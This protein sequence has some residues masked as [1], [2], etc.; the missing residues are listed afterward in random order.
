MKIVWCILLVPVLLLACRKKDKDKNNA[1]NGSN[2]FAY[3][4]KYDSVISTPDNLTYNFAFYINVSAGNI[5]SNRLTCSV[6]GLPALVSVSPSSQTVGNLLGGVFSFTI[7]SLPYGDYPFQLKVQS[8]KY[9]IQT[10]NAVLRI[11]PAPD[12]APMLVG[13]Y[14]SC[15]DFCSQTG[16]NPKYGATVSNVFD[17]AFL[18]KVTNVHNWGSAAVLRAWV[19]N[20]ITVPLQTVNG[21]TMW[22]SG[23]YSHDARPMHEGHYI[24]EIKDTF[25]VASDTEYCTIHIEH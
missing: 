9:G 5:D 17:T 7:H 16:V 3:T 21:K 4:I 19:G 23:T 25:A 20:A 18:L 8:V 11:I 13:I 15:Y 14:D 10:Y 24:I 1:G 6:E 2:D 12:Y 22:G